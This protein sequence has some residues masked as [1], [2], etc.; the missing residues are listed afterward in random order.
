MQVAHA[1]DEENVG[2]GGKEDHVLDLK[3]KFRG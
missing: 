1:V 2:E 3:E